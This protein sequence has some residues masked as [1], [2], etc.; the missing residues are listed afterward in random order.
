MHVIN[1]TCA[2]SVRRLRTFCVLGRDFT[3]PFDQR[4]NVRTKVRAEMR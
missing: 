3:Y 4:R 1:I 2:F